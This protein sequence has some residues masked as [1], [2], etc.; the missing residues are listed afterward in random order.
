M[1]GDRS[2]QI[3]QLCDAWRQA[4][5]LPNGSIAIGGA[6]EQHRLRANGIQPHDLSY[7]ELRAA[8]VGLI[9]VLL[10]PGLSTVIDEDHEWFWAWGAE[11]LLARGNGLFF[12]AEAEI[13]GLVETTVRAALAPSRS[14]RYSSI[15]RSVRQ[16]S[17]R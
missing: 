8:C 3:R 14:D 10:L 13:R 1:S 6:S 16:L 7:N 12:D 15:E 11:I 17:C 2:A 9:G 4:V 5:L